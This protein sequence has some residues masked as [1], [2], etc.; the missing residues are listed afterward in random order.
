MPHKRKRLVNLRQ[1]LGVAGSRMFLLIIH[2]EKGVCLD[3]DTPLSF[4]SNY[5]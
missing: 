4:R 1:L 2:K 5:N 3:K